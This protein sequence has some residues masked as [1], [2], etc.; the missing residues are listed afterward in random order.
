MTGINEE[1]VDL[2][3]YLRIVAASLKQIP[4]S[5]DESLQKKLDRVTG[6]TLTELEDLE[7]RLIKKMPDFTPHIMESSKLVEAK[8]IERMT[9][10][11]DNVRQALYD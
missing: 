3:D 5:I 1:T 4:V 6:W 11:T 8:V 10:F 2:H 7:K 9:S